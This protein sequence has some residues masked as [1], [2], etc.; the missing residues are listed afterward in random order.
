MK[1][2]E[3]VQEIHMLIQ[4]HGSFHLIRSRIQRH[5]YISITSSLPSPSRTLLRAVS[6][7]KKHCCA[8]EFATCMITII[9]A[10]AITQRHGTQYLSNTKLHVTHITEVNQNLPQCRSEQTGCY[11]G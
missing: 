2:I 8:H 10:F 7:A 11:S 9:S 6:G 4:N 1:I 5:I 3:P